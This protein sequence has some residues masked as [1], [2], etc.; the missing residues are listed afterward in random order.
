MAE[1]L[2]AA[3][4]RRAVLVSSAPAPGS[5]PALRRFEARFREHFGRAPGPYAAVGYEAMRSVLAAIAAAGPQAG[6]RQAIIDAY[7]GAGERRGTLLGD[8]RIAGDGRRVPA[9]FTT[10]SSPASRRG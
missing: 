6:R 3:A 10:L 8:Y 2:S 9:P 5:T 1:R 7:F 4:R